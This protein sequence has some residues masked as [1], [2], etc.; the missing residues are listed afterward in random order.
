MDRG[1]QKSPAHKVG[2][3]MHACQWQGGGCGYL[4]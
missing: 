1:E 4:P 2:T 3:C